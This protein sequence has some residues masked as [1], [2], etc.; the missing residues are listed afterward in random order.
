[1]PHR[2]WVSLSP[3]PPWKPEQ[4]LLRRPRVPARREPKGIQ[5]D[6]NCPAPPHLPTMLCLSFHKVPLSQF[7]GSPKQGMQ[8]YGE[9]RA[10]SSQWGSAKW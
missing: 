9:P 6:V 8:C 3:A 7:L 10:G 5:E 1:M 2:W 4:G